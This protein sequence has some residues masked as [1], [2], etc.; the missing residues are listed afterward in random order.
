M[1]A[2]G[3]GWEGW[4]TNAGQKIKNELASSSWFC[5]PVR[6]AKYTRQSLQD[7]TDGERF[8]LTVRSLTFIPL[9][10]SKVFFFLTLT[11]FCDKIKK[12]SLASPPPPSDQL[13]ASRYYIRF[14]T[15]TNTAALHY[16]CFV[17]KLLKEGDAQMLIHTHTRAERSGLTLRC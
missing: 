13:S 12:D 2:G 14:P 1:T 17:L 9:Y 8:R 16:F 10:S 4:A 15:I 6:W 3:G 11:I 5:V 7:A